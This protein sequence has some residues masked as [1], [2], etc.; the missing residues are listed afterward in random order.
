[1]RETPPAI[2]AGERPLSGV[3]SAV[4]LKCPGLAE[5]FSAVGTAVG[6]GTCVYVEVNAQIAMRVERT[7]ALGAQEAT[8]FRRMLGSLVL[9][10]LRWPRERSIAVHAWELLQALLLRVALLM[11]QELGTG[12]EGALTGQAREG[13]E[14][15]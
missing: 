14:R 10:Q 9:Q 3:N 7:T 13:R 1:M 4:N 2:S 8:H 11:A 6:P 12:G 5:A 15:I